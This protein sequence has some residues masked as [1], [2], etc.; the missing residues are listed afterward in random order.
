M[1]TTRENLEVVVAWLDAMRRRDLAS[2]EKVLEPEV[3]WRGLPDGAV[4]EN[5]DEVLD[6]LRTDELHEGLRSIDALELVAGD[7]AVVLGVRSPELTEI[8]DVPLDGQ[9]FNVFGVRE[10]RIASIQDYA[11]RAD[12][13]AA[14][15][16]R[17]PAW[18]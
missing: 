5:L 17:T 1:S 4:C 15:G 13:L 16:A 8:G 6:M 11:K 3:V 10:G 12:A 7:G 14:A 2:I 9:L 18:T